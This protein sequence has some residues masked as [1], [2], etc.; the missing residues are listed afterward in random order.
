[1]SNALLEAQAWGLPCVASDIPANR[2]VA[3]DGEN[4][5]FVPAGDSAALAEG[6]FRLLEDETLCR[7]LGEAARRNIERNFDIRVTAGRLAAVYRRLVA[8]D[9]GNATLS[10]KEGCR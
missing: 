5:L 10:V 1:M 4:A 3:T 7:Q 6:I 2:A 9:S 8:E